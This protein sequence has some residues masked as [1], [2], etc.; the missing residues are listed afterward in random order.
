MPS[1][2]A[3]A[4]NQPMPAPL[5]RPAQAR[6]QGTSPAKRWPRRRERTSHVV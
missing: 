6:R 3:A 1:R 5:L 2:A 4:S